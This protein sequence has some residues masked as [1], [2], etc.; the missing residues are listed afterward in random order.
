MEEKI[1]N[2][3]HAGPE[4]AAAAPDSPEELARKGMEYDVLSARLEEALRQLEELRAA[5]PTA[6]ERRRR[7]CARFLDRFPREAARLISGAE[8]LPGEVWARVKAGD[9]LAEAYADYANR[10]ELA[11]RGEEIERL[12]RE[13]EALRQE[14]QNARRS[15]GSARSRGEEP[16]YD[17]AAAGWNSI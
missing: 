1:I 2:T 6:D 8:Q 7:D 9:G 14:R 17:P 16:A 11:R 12:R 5:M 4:E 3:A 13:A 10:A 15:T